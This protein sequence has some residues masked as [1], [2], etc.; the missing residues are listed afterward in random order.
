MCAAGV[1]GV[2]DDPRPPWERRPTPDPADLGDYDPRNLVRVVDA[3]R[4]EDFDLVLPLWC[5]PHG[6]GNTTNY[7]ASPLLFASHRARIRQ[8][9]AGH[10]LLRRTLIRQLDVD[11]L[12]D[13]YGIDIV[14]IRLR[15][16]N[17]PPE[18]VPAITQ[19]I[20][21][22]VERLV[23]CD[24]AQYLWLHRRWK[25]QPHSKAKKAA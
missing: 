1:A 18:V 6:Q 21:T 4:D 25:H 24:P 2:D 14:D 9:L 12:P 3:A 7:L 20:T 16:Y 23:R 10:M 22:A 11:A 17:Y 15:R 5:R 8:P 13:D 19:R